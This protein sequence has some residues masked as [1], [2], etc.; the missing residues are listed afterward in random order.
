ME[1]G[2]FDRNKICIS[3]LLHLQTVPCQQ[4]IKAKAQTRHYVTVGRLVGV[5]TLFYM[6]GQSNASLVS[7]TA[8][9]P[10]G[11][12]H[13]YNTHHQG[14]SL[15][16]DPYHTADQGTLAGDVQNWAMLIQNYILW[17]SK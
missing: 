9:F 15:Y 17:V 4:C 3:E 1:A 2:D 16:Y 5:F 13:L 14:H 11:Y 10:H 6:V 7:H 12:T 8:P